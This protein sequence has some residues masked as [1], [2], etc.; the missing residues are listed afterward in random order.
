[1]LRPPFV[2]TALTCGVFAGQKR[3]PSQN[4]RRHFSPF[5]RLTATVVACASLMRARKTRA[6]AL[7]RVLYRERERARARAHAHATNH[8]VSR[9]AAFGKRSRASV[10]GVIN[11]QSVWRRRRRLSSSAVGCRRLPSVAV[12]CRRLQSPRGQRSRV[13]N[14]KRRARSSQILRSPASERARLCV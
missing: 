13:Y 6:A 5:V 14:K 4:L 3:L 9:R 7:W 12:V 1:M 2:A 11:A 10:Q 8:F